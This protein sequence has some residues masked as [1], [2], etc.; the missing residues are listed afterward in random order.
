M[1]KKLQTN[2][3]LDKIIVKNQQNKS[4]NVLKKYNNT[5]LAQG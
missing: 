2:V 1:K 4:S 5:R 3:T